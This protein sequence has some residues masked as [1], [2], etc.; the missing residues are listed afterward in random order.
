MTKTLTL[1]TELLPDGSDALCGAALSAEY[2]GGQ[3]TALYAVASSGSLELFRGEG[4]GRL[5]RELTN[6]IALAEDHYPEDADHLRAF[7][8][9]VAEHFPPYE[10]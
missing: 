9:Y 6:A 4:T 8:D 1:T 5:L 10:D 7:H 2:Y 3:F